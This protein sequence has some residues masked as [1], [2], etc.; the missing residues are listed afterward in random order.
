MTMLMP[1]HLQTLQEIETVMRA[2][3]MGG[4]I[5]GRLPLRCGVADEMVHE[6]AEALGVGGWEVGGVR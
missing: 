4:A 1:T 3:E 5:L 6:G 2:I